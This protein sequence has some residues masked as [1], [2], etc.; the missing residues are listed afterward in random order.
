MAWSGNISSGSKRLGC[1]HC[2]EEEEREKR[3]RERE[4]SW[5]TKK[6]MKL[7]LAKEN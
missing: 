3:E 4:A 2:P 1:W 6:E 7:G 5:V